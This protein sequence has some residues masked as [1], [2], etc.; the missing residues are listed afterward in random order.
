MKKRHYLDRVPE[1]RS[2]AVRF[3]GARDLAA[4]LNSFNQPFLRGPIRRRQARARAV[5]LHRGA[6]NPELAYS[7]IEQKRTTAFS[8]TIPVS[9]AIECVASS[10]RREH[11]SSA[12]RDKHC[13]FQ[14]TF[15]TDAGL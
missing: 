4:L 3:Q 5:L 6:A 13:Y 9:T 10:E 1:R 7:C 12:K 14:Q 8:A 2:R 11:T 15:S